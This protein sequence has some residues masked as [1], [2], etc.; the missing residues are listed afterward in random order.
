ML[1]V[2]RCR[3]ATERSPASLDGEFGALYGSK[4]WRERPPQRE[5]ET[6]H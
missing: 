1:V 4:P 3:S 5:I 6:A 2:A